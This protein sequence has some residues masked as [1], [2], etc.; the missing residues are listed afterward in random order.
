MQKT[1]VFKDRKAAFA[2]LVQYDILVS[3]GIMKL[4]EGSLM[5]AF[6]YHGPDITNSSPEQVNSLSRSVSRVLAGI[7]EQYLLHIDHVR[8]PVANYEHSQFPDAATAL[9]DTV[10]HVAAR[11]DGARFASSQIITVTW[12]PPSQFEQKFFSRLISGAKEVV[13][14]EMQ[15]L[16]ASVQKFNT[17]LLDI[18]GS[19]RSCDKDIMV[20]PLDSASLLSHLYFCTTGIRQK[21]A[22]PHTPVF[23]D[24]LL[25]SQDFF[26]G[27]HPKVGRK[28]VRCLSIEGFP[29]STHPTILDLLTKT[30]VEYR[31]NTRWIPH[32]R[33]FSEKIISKTRKHWTDA[34]VSAWDKFAQSWGGRGSGRTNS[35]AAQR[36][37]EADLALNLARSGDVRFGFYTSTLVFFHEDD[38][39]LSTIVRDLEKQL[40]N[41]NFSVRNE[42]FNC[43]EAFLG[44]LP[45]HGHENVRWPVIHTKN[46]SDLMALH[47]VWSGHE[48]CPN[49]M[50]PEGSPPLIYAATSGGSPFRV[51]LHVGNLGHTT[52]IGPSGAG[53]STLLATLMA[54]FFRYY[55]PEKNVHPQVFMFDKGASSFVLC[56]AAGGEF[57]D[58]AAENQ[59]ISFAPLADID[60]QGERDWAEKW[61]E[62]LILLQSGETR[63]EPS[64]R[65]EI[66][67]G[68]E[69]LS[70]SP[71]DARTLTELVGTLSSPFADRSDYF[72][73]MLGEYLIDAGSVSGRMLDATRSSLGDANFQVFEL[74]HLMNLGTTQ[75]LPVLSYL[76]H[77]IE[78]RLKE[79]R[80]TLIVMDEAWLMLKH[81]Y[82]QEKIVEWMR[83]L[84][85][86]NAVIVFATQNVNDI[87]G[88][89]IAAA[90]LTN[91]ATKIWLPN[92]E[93]STPF[94]AEFYRQAGLSETQIQIL[95]QVAQPQRDYLLTNA[96]GKRLFQLALDP[97][98]L[99]LLAASG[100]ADLALARAMIDQHGE[101]WVY[102]WLRHWGFAQWADYYDELRRKPVFTNALD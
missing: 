75:T 95:S 70:S 84:R 82:F 71:R 2:N 57:Y 81:P 85:R 28:H 80:P 20:R 69:Y 9:I 55:Q 89:E 78:R 100:K 13:G 49:P 41:L 68:L 43:V 77:A 1:S 62:G 4:K 59:D 26:G 72:R 73:E 25:C 14:N 51:N 65:S 23:M 64:V 50:M 27:M 8:M 21:L 30:Q 48:K 7:G 52:I 24:Y 22:L 39:L 88:S 18:A 16:R 79:G 63:L 44:A 33:Q 17:A 19:L 32:S 67:K 90:I 29:D 56:K 47:T 40:E 86:S 60:Q 10:R 101:D 42:E 53:K 6:E 92:K 54:Q 36:A 5:A 34:E 45:G 31:W 97:L 87:I 35:F 74:D 83:T 15:A 91:V 94:M 99:K 46:L 12:L 98:Q 93:A 3:E 76:F 37:N 58:L 38:K 102:H 96:D 11:Q 66:R 61:I